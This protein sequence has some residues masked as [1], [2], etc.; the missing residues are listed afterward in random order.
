MHGA[1]FLNT[2]VQEAN[3]SFSQ[4]FLRV[5]VP[6]VSPL[7][8]GVTLWRGRSQ[9]EETR[10]QNNDSFPG[11]DSKRG[12]MGLAGKFVCFE[13]KPGRKQHVSGGSGGCTLQMHF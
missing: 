11:K 10:L 3:G 6:L 12:C 7:L 1:T 2:L 4:L 8:L 13:F 5:Q 9:R